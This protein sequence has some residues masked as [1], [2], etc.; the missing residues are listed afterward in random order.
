MTEP[1]DA[2]ARLI[3]D[4]ASKR[5]LHYGYGK[6]TMS[7]VARDC[8]MST[9]NLYRFFPSKL[10]IA[11]AFVRGLRAEQ[12]AKLRAAAG[13]A[14]LPA[15]ERLRRVLRAK[16]KLAYERFHDRPKA[17]E[18]AN[19]VIMERPEVAAE[20]ETAEGVLIG[21]ILTEGAARGEF[22]PT[23]SQM[24]RLIQD[25]AFRFTTPAVFHEGD[26][27]KLVAE[28]DDLVSLLLDAFAFRLASATPL[29]SPLEPASKKSTAYLAD[30]A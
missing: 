10:D 12:T 17:L 22:P 5:F 3:L 2:T 8:N 15:A 27:P 26:L 6:T 4:A 19:E 30:L 11:V 29:S 21:E 9:G 14:D 25:I 1:A 24:P 18:L 28:L 20:W 23:G 13:S 7:E 16:L